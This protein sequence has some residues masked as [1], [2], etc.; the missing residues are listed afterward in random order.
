MEDSTPESVP[1]CRARTSS[2]RFSGGNTSVFK[3]SLE[4]YRPVCSD[5]SAPPIFVCACVS[6]A[7]AFCSVLTVCCMLC[8][9]S[10]YCWFCTSRNEIAAAK[11]SFRYCSFSSLSCAIMRSFWSMTV[12]SA[13]IRRFSCPS[14]AASCDCICAICVST[15][16]PAC[17]SCASARARMPSS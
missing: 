7:E 16:A 11:V 6:C 10:T 14:A 13:G 1:P 4:S 12:C 15:A 2:A 17:A 3:S 9:S 5:C 8:F